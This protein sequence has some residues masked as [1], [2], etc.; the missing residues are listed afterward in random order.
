MKKNQ[1][2]NIL[3]YIHLFTLVLVL[4]SAVFSIFSGARIT[5]SFEYNSFMFGLVSIYNTILMIF[6]V[7]MLIARKDFRKKK[8]VI[9]MCINIVVVPF[10]A[11]YFMLS[12]AM[13]LV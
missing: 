5:F 7:I 10:I 2:F 3:F 1:L 8:L 4:L 6:S 13:Y 12:Y 9:L 11:S